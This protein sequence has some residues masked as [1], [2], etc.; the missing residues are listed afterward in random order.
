MFCVRGV[1]GVVRAS[2]SLVPPFVS[3]WGGPT[4]Q[5]QFLGATVLSLVFVRVGLL[6][7]EVAGT[8]R[9]V[10]GTSL[11][12]SVSRGLPRDQE[13]RGYLAVNVRS[14]SGW[15]FVIYW[16]GGGR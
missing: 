10:R 16:S 1:C 11:A 7:R 4:K 12:P 13:K 5:A 8:G 15:V 14:M 3:T 9:P 2:S 6:G